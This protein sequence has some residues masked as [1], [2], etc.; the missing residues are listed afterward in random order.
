MSILGRAVNFIYHVREGNCGPKRI[1]VNGSE[2]AFNTLENQYRRGGA[3]L[4][5][6][7][8]EGMLSPVENG[9]EIFL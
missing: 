7:L 8:F 2:V 6:F 9:V 4:D 5:E 3:A 1:T